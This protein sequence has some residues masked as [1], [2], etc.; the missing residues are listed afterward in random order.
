MNNMLNA[1]PLLILIPSVKVFKRTDG[2]QFITQ[3]FVD[4]VRQYQ[5]QWPGRVEV[6]I[7]QT[8]QADDNLD[9]IDIEQIHNIT[10]T[11]I[12]FDDIDRKLATITQP[13]VALAFSHF[14]QNGIAKKC[15]HYGI[16]CVL[17]SEYTLTT[18]R[19]IIKAN[20]K[21]WLRRC[22]AYLWEYQQEKK[23]LESVRLSSAI[24]CN[25]L[26]TYLAYKQINNNCL[27]YFDSRVRKED[28]IDK[29]KLL[30]RTQYCLQGNTL[31]LV[32]SGRLNRMKG[33]D[34]LILVAKSLND[35]QV[36]FHLTICGDG[37]LRQSM[38]ESVK[39]WQLGDRVT[40]TGVLNFHKELLPFIKDNTDLFICCHR[41]G[42]PS[43]TYIETMS[44]GVP[45][46][47]YDNE[48]FTGLQQTAHCGWK[49]PM[50]KYRL[51]AKTV[52]RL[53]QNRS[54]IVD[55]SIKSREFSLD[56]TFENTFARRVEHLKN[57]VN[58]V[59]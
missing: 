1:T 51:L 8:H 42:D 9:K 47:S 50:D 28:V 54:E 5:K 52:Q 55:H 27:L 17:V 48:A 58:A 59:Q 11:I 12:N 10:L 26:P 36:D 29:D 33:A 6:Y 45:I 35:L 40:F 21:S 3:K 53:D 44:C 25:G 37:E 38:L 18:R 39:H 34:H 57:I 30:K 7:E 15:L 13:A 4:G 14:R 41:Q 32:F 46:V 19:Q 20:H 31:R 43:C 2:K 22:R 24:Q 49:T 56:N 23:N 16:R